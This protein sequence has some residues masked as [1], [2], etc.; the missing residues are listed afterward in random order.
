MK[1][2]ISLRVI[3]PL[4]CLVFLA[5][6][7]AV[8]RVP[9]VRYLPLLGESTDSSMEGILSVALKD[10]NPLVRRDAVNLLATMVSTPE[11][12]RRSAAALGRALNDR[13]EDIRLD[14][15]RGLGNIPNEIS[16]PYLNKAMKDKSVRVRVEVIRVLG[17]SYNQRASQLRRTTPAEG[18]Q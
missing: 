11:E 12:Q 7:C 9:P 16:G 6:S 2:K 4:V 13:E 1:N 8:R 15:V 5:A 17:N 18:G 14:A 3:L 10:K